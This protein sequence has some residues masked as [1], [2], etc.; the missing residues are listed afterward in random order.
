MEIFVYFVKTCRNFPYIL[1]KY[2]IRKYFTHFYETKYFSQITK[3]IRPEIN[4]LNFD[5]KIFRTG[6]FKIPGENFVEK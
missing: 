4:R 3:R 6:I 1:K 2:K 5:L